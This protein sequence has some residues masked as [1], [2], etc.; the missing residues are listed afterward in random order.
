MNPSPLTVAVLDDEAKFRQAQTRLL[1]T[2]GL[3]VETFETGN[4]LLAAL[5][6]ERFGCV[7]LDLHMPGMTGFDVLAEL[8]TQEPRTPV[9]VITGHDEPGNALRVRALG[10]MEYLLKP[11]DESKPMAPIGTVTQ[12]REKNQPTSQQPIES[13]RSH[14]Y[15]A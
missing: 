5:A 6:R 7:L 4:V 10:A 13:R 14:C 15:E 9:I 2:H 8:A 1:K 3:K 11:V 12:P